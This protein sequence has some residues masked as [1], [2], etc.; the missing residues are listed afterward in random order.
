MGLAAVPYMDMISPTDILPVTLLAALV[1]PVITGRGA[2]TSSVTLMMVVPVAGL[3]PAT[4]MVPVYGDPEGNRELSIDGM[5][6]AL[7]LNVPV[8]GVVPEVGVIS[9]QPAALAAAAV[10]V[11]DDPPPVTWIVAVGLVPPTR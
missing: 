10:K 9:S 5:T 4:V 7:R 3:V 1:I 2:V 6:E 11:A 8:L